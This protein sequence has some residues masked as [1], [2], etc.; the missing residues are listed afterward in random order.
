[1]NSPD[2]RRGRNLLELE[3]VVLARKPHSPLPL[4]KECDLSVT[5]SRLQVLD[6]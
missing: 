2:R 3:R 5:Q 1:M 6:L 4:I